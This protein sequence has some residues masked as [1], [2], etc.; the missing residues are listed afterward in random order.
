M[1]KMTQTV[2]MWLSRKDK[3]GYGELVGQTGWWSRLQ[4]LYLQRERI[5][6]GSAS[7][8]ICDVEWTA[9]GFLWAWEFV[10]EQAFFI[11]FIAYSFTCSGINLCINRMLLGSMQRYSCLCS[12]SM[13][14]RVTRHSVIAAFFWMQLTVCRA[15]PGNVCFAGISLKA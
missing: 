5:Y 4:H 13:A 14:S 8:L 10:G 12:S 1:A 11:Y 6:L 3:T 9:V 7:G 2:G 15:S